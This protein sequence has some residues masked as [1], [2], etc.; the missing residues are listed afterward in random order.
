MFVVGVRVLPW[1]LKLVAASGSRELFTLT[2]LVVALGIAVGSAK[3]FDVSMAL[4][5]FL[6]GMVVGRSEFSLRAASEALPMRDAFAVLFFVSVGMMFNPKLFLESPLASILALLIVIVGKPLAAFG[7]VLL[8]GYPLRVALGVA[9]ALGQIGEFSFILAALGRSMNVLPEAATN[10]LVAAAIIS[11]SLNPMLYR[12]IGRFDTWITNRPRLNRW[13]ARRSNPVES[14]PVPPSPERK[15]V[16]RAVV[17]GFGPVGRTLSR[18]LRENDIEPTIIELN[19]DTAQRLTREGTAAVYGDASQP[20]TLKAAGVEGAR[21]LILSSSGLPNAQEIIR[22]ARELNPELRVLVRCAYLREIPALRSAGADGVFAGEGEVA[23]AMTESL[24]RDLGAVD[25]QIDRER[26][27][28]R[29]E[30]FEA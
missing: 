26:E 28:V 8:R 23:L 6:A 27:R 9:V 12:A 14:V 10:A 25:E 3:L 24:L 4:G 16:F 21:G 30:L 13:L 22:R 20:E 7:I 19:L 2:V 29:T 17:V 11:I 1:L 5:A 15:D 18:L